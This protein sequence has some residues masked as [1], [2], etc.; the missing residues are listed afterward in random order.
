MAL[1]FDP[2]SHFGG[3][4]CMEQTLMDKL[5]I[6]ADSAKYDVACTSSGVDRK[7]N[8][9]GMGNSIAP[10]ICHTFSADGR[11][12]SLLKILFTN[13]CI[14]RCAYCQNNCNND[15]PRASFTPDEV[16][17]AEIILKVFS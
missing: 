9:H 14:F 8:G 11:C 7:G 1:F 10:G 5:T 17:T 13:E 2:F 15:V 12:I 3:V 16:F 4:F 6:L